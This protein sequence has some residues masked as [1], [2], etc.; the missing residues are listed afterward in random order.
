MGLIMFEGKVILITG[1]TGSFGKWLTRE[2]LKHDVKEIRI[3]SRD[4]EKQLDMSREFSDPRLKFIIGD[5]RDYKRVLEAT[6]GVHILYHAAALKIVPLCEQY[7]VEALKTN[8]L[9]TI[10]V[11]KAA[12]NNNVKRSLLVSTDKAVQPINLY[13]M[14]KAIAEKNWLNNEFTTKSKFTVVRYGNVIGS[15]G[16]V[17]PYFKQLIKE[18]KPLPITHPNMTR[19]LFTL[20]QAV[21]LVFYATENIEG[22]EIY[23]PKIPAC[24]IMDLAKVLADDNYP[25]EIIG[26]RP[27]EKIYECLVQEDEFRR[28]KETEDYY[29]IYPYGRYSSE[30]IREEFTSENARQLNREEIAKLLKDAGCL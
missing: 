29:I 13:G 12:I 7:P 10:Y 19:F 4:E 20:Q 3:Y 14:T 26:I 2:L 5:V 23:V 17:I 30:K 6:Q 15:R 25:I 9:G 18:N 16:S 1:G 8:T 28:T 27:G 22:G 11:K 21:N 24:N